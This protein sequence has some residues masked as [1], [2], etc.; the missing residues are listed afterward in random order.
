MQNVLTKAKKD[1]E[2][3]FY[4]GIMELAKQRY[5]EG[6]QEFSNVRVI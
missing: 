3:F 4:K 2:L 5:A 6:F 1:P